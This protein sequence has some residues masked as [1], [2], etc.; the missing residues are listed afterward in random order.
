M[1]ES[2]RRH[3]GHQF[4]ERVRYPRPMRKLTRVLVSTTFLITLGACSSSSS[5]DST[6]VSDSTS[7]SDTSVP[8]EGPVQIGVTVGQNDFT[9]TN[10]ADGVFDVPLGASVEIFV[11][12]PSAD[13]EFHLHGYDL[14][15]STTKGQTGTISFTADQ[16]GEFEIESHISE[17]VVAKIIVK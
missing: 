5:S 12:N 10:G 6:V 2:R 1:N 3:R 11:T 13:D 17:T 4:R 9:S 15:A 7:A 16:V 14:E 8:S